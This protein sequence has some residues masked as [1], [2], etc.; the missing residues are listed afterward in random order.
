MTESC[1]LIT[2]QYQEYLKLKAEHKPLS[3]NELKE[4]AK[5]IGYFLNKDYQNDEFLSKRIGEKFYC[6]RQEGAI[7]NGQYYGIIAEHRTPEQMLAI[8]KALQ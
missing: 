1:R 8:M 6:F 4:K 7:D 2:E 3:W 5:E